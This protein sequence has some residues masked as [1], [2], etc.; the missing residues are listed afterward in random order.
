MPFRLL[1]F[2][3]RFNPKPTPMPAGALKAKIGISK[4]KRIWKRLEGDDFVYTKAQST[5]ILLKG[6]YK[7]LRELAGKESDRVTLN[8]TGSMMRALKVT[9]VNEAEGS[10][11]ISF[12]DNRASELAGFHHR[13]AGR[14]KVKRI[15]LS[16]SEE[17]L[18]KL[19]SGVKFSF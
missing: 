9:N 17:E 16:L 10:V 8:W 4:A 18:N 11:T 19:T 12:T 6:G 1:I 2:V 5:W 7:R 15:F 13:G 14:N 3:H